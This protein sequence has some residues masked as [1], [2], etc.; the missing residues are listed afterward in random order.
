V[1]DA[2]VVGVPSVVSAVG[3]LPFVVVQGATGWIVKD[4]SGWGDV[5]QEV[6]RGFSATRA[7]GEAALCH[8]E[9]R[10]A[11]TEGAH[12]IS[13]GLLDWIRA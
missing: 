12:I 3:D 9:R 6:A 1:L 4:P 2:A 11:A 13:P 10:W 5:L 7:I 8:V